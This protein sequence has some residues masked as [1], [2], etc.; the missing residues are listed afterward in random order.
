MSAEHPL[1]AFFG[2]HKAGTMWVC[3]V[4]RALCAQ[5]GWTTSY[6][7]S[8]KSF[9]FDLPRFLAPGDVDV[10]LYVNADARFVDLVEN[11]RGFHV[12]RDPRDV[13]VS[14]YFSHLHSH[15]TDGWPE[16]VELRSELERLPKAE[17]LMR[18]LEFTRDLQTDGVALRPFECMRSWSYAQPNVMEV[19]FEELIA[20]PQEVFLEIF[21]F[22]DVVDESRL[23]AA[24]FP[25]RRLL[26]ALPGFGPRPRG[27]V[28]GKIPLARARQIT[29]QRGFSKLTG[30][31]PLGEEDVKN[32]LRRGVAGDWKNH[33]D[34]T[35]KE[36]FKSHFNDVLVKLRYETSDDW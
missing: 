1:F 19:R 10:L 35:H 23:G 30:G 3:G 34:E 31:R 22:L 18:D 24:L 15:P 8:P 5:L 28:P 14:A 36:Y 16:L 13:A 20:A 9:G 7:Y 33:F 2:H 26:R 11:L 12:I 4:L 27:A 25:F 29:A 6:H 32:H 21:R 17:G